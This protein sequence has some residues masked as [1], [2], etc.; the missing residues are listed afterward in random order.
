M[1]ASA[2]A[3]AELPRLRVP[4]TLPALSTERLR[5]R[6]LTEDD[7]A[8][9]AAYQ[10]RDD[11]VRYLPWPLRDRAASAQHTRERATLTS[12]A[13]TGDR[14]ILAISKPA[15]DGRS[16]VIGD[17]TL[18]AASVPDAQL[19][20]GW[21]LH[22]DFQGAG[23]ASEAAGA[24]LRL[25][26]EQFGAHR[27]SARLDPR[28]GA[29]AAL[30]ER[31]GMRREALFRHDIFFKGEWGDTAIYAILAEEWAARDPQA[32]RDSRRIVP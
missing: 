27:V 26:F 19:E 15:G 31:L 4:F 3:S 30:C 21:V 23:Y 5:L 29:S 11:V 6:P 13:K 17:L 1:T 18:I 8:D 14:A 12:I 22:P 9:V 25:C 2:S 32:P 16:R 28:N 7:V 20:I 10:T 24:L